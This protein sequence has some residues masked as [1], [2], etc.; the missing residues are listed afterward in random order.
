MGLL[1][2][3]AGR[4]QKEE[5]TSESCQEGPAYLHLMKARTVRMKN[6]RGQIVRRKSNSF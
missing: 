3:A 6:E 4:E 1:R 5:A 2:K